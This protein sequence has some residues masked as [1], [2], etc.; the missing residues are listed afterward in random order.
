[1]YCNEQLKIKPGQ[2]DRISCIHF[3]ERSF[4]QTCSHIRFSTD[5]G[6]W[7][8]VFVICCLFICLISLSL[9]TE[10]SWL[11]DDHAHHADV[12]LNVLCIDAV[13]TGCI[14][15]FY[16][17]Q[18]FLAVVQT[19]PISDLGESLDQGLCPRCH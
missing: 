6:L 19:E 5:L 17:F 10:G 9:K 14:I 16:C 4:I 18:A 13:Y 8:A 12:S 11:Q 2:A 1:M 15:H 7:I 3:H